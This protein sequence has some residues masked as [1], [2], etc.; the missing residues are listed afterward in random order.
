ML[1][2]SCNNS[3][4]KGKGCRTLAC[5]SVVQGQYEIGRTLTSSELSGKIKMNNN[6]LNDI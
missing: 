2:I 1:L 4:G 5:T 3:Q 6:Y